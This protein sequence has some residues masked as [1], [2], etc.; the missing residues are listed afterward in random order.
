MQTLDDMVKI[1]KENCDYIK[2]QLKNKMNFEFDEEF[3]EI[4]DSIK[5]IVKIF[6]LNTD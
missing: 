4:S 1:I 6:D 2:D 3:N 5:G